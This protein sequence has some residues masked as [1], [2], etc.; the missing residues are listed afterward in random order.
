MLPLMR[1]LYRIAHISN[2]LCCKK[3]IM[4]VMDPSCAVFLMVNYFRRKGEEREYLVKWKELPYDEC[5]WEFKSDISA[6]QPQ[7]DRY[8]KIQSNASRKLSK[9]KIFDRSSRE[10]KHKQRE[11]QQY[12]STPTFLSDGAFL[13][14]ELCDFPQFLS[15]RIL[16]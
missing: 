4:E 16:F 9:P 14:T 7:I 15:C 3:G 8:Y 6:F 5:S 13:Y 2:F 12:D 11:F 1:M 10:P